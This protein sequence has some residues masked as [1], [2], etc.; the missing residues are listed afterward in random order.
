V[1]RN[2]GALALWDQL[3]REEIEKKVETRKREIEFIQQV[4]STAPHVILCLKAH[5]EDFITNLQLLK[6]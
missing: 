3:D 1:A 6:F 2:P 4:P 5:C